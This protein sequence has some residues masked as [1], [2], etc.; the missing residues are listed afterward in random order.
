MGN[1]PT[2]SQKVLEQLTSLS[3]ALAAHV[4]IGVNT[5]KKID[6]MYEILVTGN[7]CPPLSE[8][9]RKH[10]E[11]ITEQENFWKEEKIEKK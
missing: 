6:A 3:L 2:L 10:T 11:W 9:V 1:I 8:T 4:A 7:G 5:D